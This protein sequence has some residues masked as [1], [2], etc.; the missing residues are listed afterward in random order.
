MECPVRAKVRPHWGRE[1][2][3][4]QIMWVGLLGYDKEIGIYSKCEATREG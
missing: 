4:S 1:G 3:A 2:D